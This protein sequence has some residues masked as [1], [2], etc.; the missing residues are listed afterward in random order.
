MNLSFISSQRNFKAVQLVV[1]IMK[2]LDII[3]SPSIAP[4]SI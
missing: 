4:G 2:D 3:K 1:G